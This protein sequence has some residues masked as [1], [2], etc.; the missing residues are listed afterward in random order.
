MVERKSPP[1]ERVVQILN[2]LADTPR[3]RLTLTQVS[4]ALDLNKPTCLGILTALTDAEF[5][6]RDAAKSYGLGPALLRLGSA[7]ESGLANL[8]LVR[9]F[10]TALHDRLGISCV[11]SA[12]HDGHIVILDR[13]GAAMAG[14]RRDLVGERLPLAPPLG[15]VNIAWEHD[16]VVDAWLSRPP[17]LPLVAGDEAAGDESVR[18]IIDGGRR[19][20]YIIECLRTSGTSTV[21][22]ASLLSS[23]LPQRI[24]DELCRHLPP[25]DWSEYLLTEPIDATA[26]IPVAHISAP[27]FDRHGSQQYTLTLVPERVDA[28]M[29]QCTQWAT[30]LVDSAQ[31]ASIAL[32]GR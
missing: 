29:A 28:T 17:L 27:I 4:A 31:H 21:V 2:L 30:A 6:T 14:D 25:T 9:P 32:G 10:V 22:L 23:G 3:E 8:D 12:A 16:T 1:T 26:T 15:L 11:L 19:R 13:L 20:G 18:A 7:A 24:I 5:V